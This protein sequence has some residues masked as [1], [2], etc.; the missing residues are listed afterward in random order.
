M[1]PFMRFPEEPRE[2]G[3][4]PGWRSPKIN[5]EVVEKFYTEQEH[6][7]QSI[8]SD[9]DNVDNADRTKA[10]SEDRNEP[11]TKACRG[12]ENTSSNESGAKEDDVPENEDPMR[13]DALHGE[14]PAL[15]LFQVQR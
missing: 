7:L 3:R 4:P 13:E 2:E 11:H 6:Q 8:S 1:P 14:L 15:E 9:E 12:K 5:Y 10:T